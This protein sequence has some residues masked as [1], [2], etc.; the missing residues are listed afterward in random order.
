[1][2]ACGRG[3][4]RASE[5][6]QHFR[7]PIRLDAIKCSA[8]WVGGLCVA[9]AL[10]CRLAAPAAAVRVHAAP[11]PDGGA[12]RSCAWFGDV[13]GAVL[14]FGVSAF[15][16]ALRA[17]GGDATADL[18]TAGPRWIG[19]FDLD[20]ERFL[21]PL[22]LRP[23]GAATGVWDVL[24]HPNGRIYFTT[25][26]DLAGSVDPATGAVQEFADAGL[27]LNE[28]ALGADGR[29]LVTRY[30]FGADSRGS[31]V[32]LSE[33]GAVIAEHV[34]HGPP[35]LRAAAKSLAF[36]PLRREVWVNTDLFPAG[37]AGGVA[38]DARVL[39]ADGREQRLVADPE[40]QFFVFARDG[41][42]YFAEVS[43]GRLRLRERSPRGLDR[44]VP[45]DD[46]FDS[47]HD[48]VQELHAE[49][50]GSVLVTRWSGRVHVVEA[51]G[52]RVRDLALPRGETGDLYYT[53]ARSGERLC[54]TRCGGIEVVCADLP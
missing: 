11:A 49:P 28:L 30:G 3:A 5:K 53:A 16:S 15:W 37:G 50:D 54:A 34:L 51:G 44:F 18:A 14:Y 26:F 52:R 19:R 4:R 25:Y 22:E 8:A 42:G 1:V 13:R 48:F 32:V 39:G 24:A 10:S 45:L 2:A 47:A 23:G 35:G 9:F 31:L 46:A 33:A 27:G 12:E 43:E 17:A 7:R 29:V 21:P 38:H 40:L 41:S 36:D 6:A 20:R